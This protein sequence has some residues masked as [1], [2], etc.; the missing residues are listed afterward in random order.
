LI[1]REEMSRLSPQGQQGNETYKK[2]KR[3][4]HHGKTKFY[5]KGNK[6]LVLRNFFDVSFAFHHVSR[7]VSTQKSGNRYS[8]TGAAIISFTITNMLQ[9]IIN[10]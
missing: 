7:H 3:F 2:Q 8:H 4:F 9:K 5:C 10:Y 6:K 1:R